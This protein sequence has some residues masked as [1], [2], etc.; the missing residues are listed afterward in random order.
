MVHPPTLQ[1]QASLKNNTE[2]SAVCNKWVQIGVQSVMHATMPTQD[3][4]YPH[5]LVLHSV[6]CP[7]NTPWAQGG[8]H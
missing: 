7:Q 8:L 2:L 3:G 5:Y 1:Y 6:G 4:P